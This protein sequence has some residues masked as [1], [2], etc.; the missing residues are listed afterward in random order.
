ME[1]FARIVSLEASH[2]H[3][4]QSRGT[5][6]EEVALVHAVLAVVLQRFDALPPHTRAAQSLIDFQFSKVRM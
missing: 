2:R 3:G 4:K 5:V 1:T 6:T